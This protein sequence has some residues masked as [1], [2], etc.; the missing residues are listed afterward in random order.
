[1][2]KLGTGESGWWRVRSSRTGQAGWVPN[3]L[4]SPKPVPVAYVYVTQTVHLRE[5]PKDLCPALQL[6]SRGAQVGHHSRERGSAAVTDQRPPL[7][8][9]EPL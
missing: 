4:L 1:M 9:Q 3:E 7:H 2:L 8:G 6:L 5:R